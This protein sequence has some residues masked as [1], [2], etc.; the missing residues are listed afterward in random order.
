MIKQ[1]KYIYQYTLNIKVYRF[2]VNPDMIGE[3]SYNFPNSTLL[4]KIC[5]INDPLT[6]HQNYESVYNVYCNSLFI[7]SEYFSL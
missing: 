3:K 5:N 1:N 2:K 6:T 4:Y 7:I